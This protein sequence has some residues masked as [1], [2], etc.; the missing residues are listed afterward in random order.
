MVVEECGNR[1]SLNVHF[2]VLTARKYKIGTYALK[3][4]LEHL[5]N[6]KNGTV[7]FLGLELTI[8]VF[9]SQIHL[10]RQSL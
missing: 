2:F 3:K 9:K 6:L 10:V 7:L 1:Q 8:H 4:S 5:K